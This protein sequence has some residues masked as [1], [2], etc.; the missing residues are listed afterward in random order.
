MKSMASQRVR[1][2]YFA[3]LQ[4]RLGLVLSWLFRSWHFSRQSTVQ[5]T[6]KIRAI[7][8]SREFVNYT[9]N[10]D[11]HSRDY[12]P[13]FISNIIG[14][15]VL[16]AENAI[17][18]LEEDQELADFHFDCIEKSNRRW[19]SDP[20]LKPGR[21]LLNYALI[22]L[23]KPKLV[24]EAGLDKGFGAIILNRALRRNSDEGFMAA[25]VGVEYRSDRPAF[26][27]EKYPYRIG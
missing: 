23:T 11:A 5:F 19:S 10:L 21:L 17:R 7:W 8:Q 9:Y 24:F 4:T 20:A 15:D 6:K 1:N 3:L 13:Y 22:R 2:F 27:I 16:E 12:L 14:C 26:L 25:Y 18:E